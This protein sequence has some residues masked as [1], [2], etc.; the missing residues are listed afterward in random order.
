MMDSI[1]KNKRT[2][3]RMPQI[4]SRQLINAARIYCMVFSPFYAPLWAFAWLFMFTYLRLSPLSYKLFILITVFM[5]TIV[6]PRITINIF[7]KINKWTHWQLSHREHR[8]TPY[9]ITIASYTACVLL[10]RNMNSAQ[11]MLSIIVATFVAGILCGVLNLWWK[12]STHVAAMGGLTGAVAA[13]GWI[14]FF[15]PV[16]MLCIMIFL[17]G[18]MGTSR[19]ILRQHSLSQVIGGFFIG[20]VCSFVFILI[21]W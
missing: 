8:Y 1:K 9:I 13:F 20:F 10:F 6:I 15:N 11:F 17:S 3:S 16:S 21:G 5:F 7:R 4:T 2:E 12:V 19:M 14:F 18:L